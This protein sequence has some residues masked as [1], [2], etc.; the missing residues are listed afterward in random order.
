MGAYNHAKLRE[1]LFGGVTRHVLQ[2]LN[3][4]VMMAH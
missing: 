2:H 3:T 1:D 4:P